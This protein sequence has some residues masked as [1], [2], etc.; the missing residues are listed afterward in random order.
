[1]LK[2][3]RKKYVRTS[4]SHHISIY[5]N[6]SIYFFISVVSLRIYILFWFKRS[7][8]RRFIGTAEERRN[9]G[10]LVA[11]HIYRITDFNH[12]L[13]CATIVFAVPPTF[14]TEW[15][16]FCIEA[17]LNAGTLAGAAGYFEAGVAQSN[18]NL[19]LMINEY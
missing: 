10:A 18:F 17:S 12:S 14:K 15:L 7:E 4:F 3:K 19:C 9:H 13:D 5:F 1:M 11:W 2:G 8:S 16:L 6:V